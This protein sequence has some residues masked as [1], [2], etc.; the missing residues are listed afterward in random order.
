MTSSHGFKRIQPKPPA[1]IVLTPTAA[2]L[3]TQLAKQNTGPKAKIPRAGRTGRTI[4]VKTVMRPKLPNTYVTSGGQK[5]VFINTDQTS[6]VAKQIQILPNLLPSGHATSK[7]SPIQSSATE[8]LALS[9]TSIPDPMPVNTSMV[10]IQPKP[11]SG[12]IRQMLNA[13]EKTE[14]PAPVRSRNTL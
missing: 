6:A 14:N 3:Q 4:L 9:S 8:K 13:H 2:E 10:T 12:T 5:F 11:V 7:E 1:T